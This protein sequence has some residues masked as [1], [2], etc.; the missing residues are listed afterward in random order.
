MAWS[1]RD[2]EIEVENRTT[3]ATT[4]NNRYCVHGKTITKK[5]QI[6]AKM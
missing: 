2:T 5:V 6:G 4:I 1:I 3:A